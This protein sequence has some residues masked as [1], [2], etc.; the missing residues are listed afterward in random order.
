MPI[1]RLSAVV[2]VSALACAACASAPPAGSRV[3][4]G[5]ASAVD[6]GGAER[7]GP[8]AAF[9]GKPLVIVPAQRTRAAAGGPAWAPTGDGARA[10]LAS[11][12]DE[13]AAALA[14]R[15][16]TRGWVL[17][18]QVERTARR[19]PT[20]ASDPH[21]LAVEPILPAA[22]AIDFEL[23]DPL[24]SQLRAI[25]ALTEGAR[26]VFVPVEARF[27]RAAPSGPADSGRAVLRLAIVDTRLAR[28]AW[29]GELA[30]DAASSLSPAI[31]ASL[32]D[33]V[34]NLAAP[35]PR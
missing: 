23:P 28:L 21:T 15:G 9:V 31:A 27:E 29:V 34:A 13:I 16:V 25:T 7:A 33:R 26:Y 1:P 10:W 24:R 12:D 20:F 22:K 5:G 8:L 30:G 35:P 32:A 11:L 6:S 4:P 17:P 3:L 2:A 18:A 19:N 14:D